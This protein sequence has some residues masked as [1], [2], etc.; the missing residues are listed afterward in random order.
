MD[1][2]TRRRYRG[3]VIRINK[4]AG[5]VTALVAIALLIK[6]LAGFG[7][8]D[9][10]E[11]ALYRAAAEGSTA[12]NILQFEL[13]FFPEGWRPGNMA[14]LALAAE[15]GFTGGGLWY[16]D[17]AP[18]RNEG[19]AAD[20]KPEQDGEQAKQPGNTEETQK[21][22]VETPEVPIP[23]DGEKLTA[24]SQALNY[25]S[26]GDIKN[27]TDYEIDIEA[28]LTQGVT[29]DMTKQSPQILIIHTHGSES[30]AP[31]A[32]DNYEESDPY[33]TEDC[34]YNMI[35]VGDTLAECFESRGYTVI[36]DT[37]LYD[38]PSYTGSYTRSMEAISAYLQEYPDIQ[39]V[40]DLHRDAIENPDGTAY[41][42]VR[43]IGDTQS[44][45]VMMVMG[46]NFSGLTHEKW[47]E[48]LK[49][50]LLI[51]ASLNCKYPGLARPISLSQYRYNQDATTG[52]MILEIGYTGN[53]LR[54][55]L[56][57]AQYF[58]D[59]ACDV[60]DLFKNQ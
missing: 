31:D 37:G 22:G 3:T 11:A 58:A 60:F 41:K 32:E 56:T 36:H 9:A 43:K 46:S 29:L 26:A 35:R 33:R 19:G 16:R 5:K 27:K 28:L 54:E 13:G 47:Q 34:A 15:T 57:A 38:Y 59:A 14:L 51:Q 18:S 42:S 8:G 49:L 12:G 50:A 23:Q 25:L 53:T 2:H 39:V 4:A 17:G 21:T 40:I 24:F 52:S 44:A 1:R 55:A 48:N 10:A 7:L 30:Y 6:L 45:P 20:G